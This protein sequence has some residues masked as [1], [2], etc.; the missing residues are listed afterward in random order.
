MAAERGLKCTCMLHDA[1]DAKR[2]AWMGE[3]ELESEDAGALDLSFQSF[4]S[5]TALG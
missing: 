4:L 2:T 1:T 5:G 3:G